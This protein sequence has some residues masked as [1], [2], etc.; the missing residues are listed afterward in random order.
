M[1]VFV[2][3]PAMMDDRR[4]RAQERGRAEAG[5]TFISYVEASVLLIPDLFPV[6]AH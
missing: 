1:Y 2:F 5:M 4:E 6:A 3:H